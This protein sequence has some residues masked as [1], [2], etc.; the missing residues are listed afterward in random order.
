MHMA[1]P[2]WSRRV[3]ERVSL[4]R[5]LTPEA[6]RQASVSWIRL[7]CLSNVANWPTLVFRNCKGSQ[8]RGVLLQDSSEHRFPIL[9]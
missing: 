5:V 2:A 9:A 4:H 8:Y 3:Q 6:I 7:Q 1:V